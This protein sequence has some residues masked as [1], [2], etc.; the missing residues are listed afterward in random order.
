MG[1][2][3]DNGTKA[4]KGAKLAFGILMICVYIGVGLLF[5]LDVFRTNNEVMNYCVGALLCVYGV[6][7]GFR[8]FKGR[9]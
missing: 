1:K 3:E 6:W 5:I 8:L 9:N 4:P 2:Y 7:R